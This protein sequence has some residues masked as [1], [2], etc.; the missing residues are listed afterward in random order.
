M[1]ER[2]WTMS[3]VALSVDNR[4]LVV[5]TIIF[6]GTFFGAP[7]E[8]SKSFMSYLMMICG[9]FLVGH[10]SG[11]SRLLSIKRGLS[12][13]MVECGCCKLGF[14]RTLGQIGEIGLVALC[15]HLDGWSQLSNLGITR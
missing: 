12:E 8:L 7:I 11:C 2:Y 14:K 5:C 1:L 13:E 10:H 9:C 6:F 4:I 15:I 3:Y